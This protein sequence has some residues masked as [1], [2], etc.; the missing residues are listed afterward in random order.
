[1]SNTKHAITQKNTDIT[2][3]EFKEMT[4]ISKMEFI[5]KNYKASKYSISGRGL[6]CGV[7]FNDVD[8]VV[9]PRFE[10]KQV[11]HPAYRAWASILWRCYDIKFLSRTPTYA[12]ATICDQWRAFSEFRKWWIANQVD[13]WHIDKDLLSD[14]KVYSPDTCI[15]IPQWL[16]KFTL[17]RDACRGDYPIGVHYS[18]RDRAF[19][20]YCSHPFRNG[21]GNLG[22]FK[23]KESASNAWLKRKLEIARE[24]KHLMDEI[25]TRLYNR[26]T[27]IITRMK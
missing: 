2:L 7:G 8:C 6:V 15:F 14:G 25:D 23:N 10:G 24:L 1:M 22:Y 19:Q 26:I 17:G 18:K 27:D 5:E 20:A 16:N 9:A 4:E 11:T 13:G 21:N 3:D 12:S